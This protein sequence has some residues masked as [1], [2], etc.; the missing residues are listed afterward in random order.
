MIYEKIESR[1]RSTELSAYKIKQ[2]EDK[3]RTKQTHKLITTVPLLNSNAM[4][5]DDSKEVRNNTT[6]KSGGQGYL[7]KD[8]YQNLCDI[9]QGKQDH[10]HRDERQDKGCTEKRMW[11]LEDKIYELEENN[12]KLKVELKASKKSNIKSKKG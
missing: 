5:S 6:T 9:S 3:Q 7:S 11:E 1:K 12:K 2:A 8:D 4:S 10:L